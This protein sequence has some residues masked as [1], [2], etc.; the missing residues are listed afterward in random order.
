VNTDVAQASHQPVGSVPAERRSFVK[1][2]AIDFNLHNYG[3]SRAPCKRLPPTLFT[4]RVAVGVMSSTAGT[5]LVLILWTHR[6]GSVGRSRA[7]TAPPRTAL[8]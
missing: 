6:I 4:N 5:N 7:Q 1:L 2:D 3:L 8:V